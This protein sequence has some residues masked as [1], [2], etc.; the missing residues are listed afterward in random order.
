MIGVKP[1]TYPRFYYKAILA[2]LIL[3]AASQWMQAQSVSI[4]STIVGTVTDPSG[5]AIPDAQVVATNI[6]TNIS[7]SAKTDSDGFYRIEPAWSLALTGSSR[8][9]RDSRN[10]RTRESPYL[11]DRPCAWISASRS[12]RWISR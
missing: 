9:T 6:S 12:E 8:R 7:T 11:P 4:Y 10:S 3:S 5:S 2:F 1:S